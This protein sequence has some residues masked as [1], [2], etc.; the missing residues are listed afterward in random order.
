MDNGI[1]R[2]KGGCRLH[3]KI[4]ASLAHAMVQGMLGT[5]QIGSGQFSGPCCSQAVEGFLVFACWPLSFRRTAQF[6]A[7]AYSPHL[8][9]TKLAHSST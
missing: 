6:P 7:A 3:G 5:A 8:C 2:G 4:M 9:H 1:S